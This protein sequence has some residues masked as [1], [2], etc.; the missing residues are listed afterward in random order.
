[1]KIYINKIIACIISLML[2]IPC[3]AFAAAKNINEKDIALLI[4]SHQKSSD[5]TSRN[6]ITLSMISAMAA[7]NREPELEKF[8]TQGEDEAFEEFATLNSKWEEIIPE[9]RNYAKVAFKNTKAN[10][11]EKYKKALQPLLNRKTALSIEEREQRILLES[12]LFTLDRIVFSER[13]QHFI[14]TNSMANHAIISDLSKAIVGREFVEDVSLDIATSIDITGT[15]GYMGYSIR[16]IRETVIRFLNDI[17]EYRARAKMAPSFPMSLSCEA[18]ADLNISAIKRTLSLERGRESFREF[19][20]LLNRRLT[21]GGLLGI[22]AVAVIGGALMLT[23]SSQ[24]S[25]QTVSNPRLFVARELK[26]TL[27]KTPSLM[28]VKTIVLRNT[29]GTDLVASVIYEN[30]DS[31]L[32]LLKKQF[33]DMDRPEV[34]AQ[35]AAVI[36]QFGA[37]SAG[38]EKKQLLKSVN[39]KAADDFAKRLNLQQF[40]FRHY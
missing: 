16:D 36:R 31:M 37:A 34:K 10:L 4:T 2:V 29:Y 19:L 24:A 23:G 1:M 7:A 12:K 5:K 21:N 18:Q 15:H 14:I 11:T 28:A 22:G 17:V 3:D 35:A 9:Y 8:I 39:K 30:K 27:Q 20:R 33:A 38:A 26:S 40:N 6:E 32:P 13:S 25:A